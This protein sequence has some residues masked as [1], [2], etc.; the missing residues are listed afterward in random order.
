MIQDQDT[1][2]LTVRDAAY[3]EQILE[4]GHTPTDD[5]RRH[6]NGTPFT[7]G[8]GRYGGVDGPRHCY[9]CCAELDKANMVETGRATLYLCGQ[10]PKAVP[11][12]WKPGTGAWSTEGTK[13]FEVTNWPGSLRFRVTGRTRG[14]HNIAR[15]RVDVWFNGPDGYV[16]HGTQYGEWTQL[17]HCKRTRERSRSRSEVALPTV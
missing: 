4:C 12:N 17:C 1:V 10:E 13:L 6:E 2:E 3:W 9:A 8:Y 16:W 5:G 15:T 11:A 7:G 14:R